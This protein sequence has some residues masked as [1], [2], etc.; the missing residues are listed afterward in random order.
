MEDVE[1]DCVLFLDEMEIATGV[2]LYR[3]EDT[4]LGGI[5]LPLKPKEPANKALVFMVGRLNQRWKQ[6]VAY[7]FTGRNVD[8]SLLKSYVLELVQLC[9]QISLRVRVVTSDM[10]PANQALWREFGFSSH[11]YSLTV[12]SIPHPCMRYGATRCELARHGKKAPR[13][14]FSTPTQLTS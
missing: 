1:K 13:S 12:C 4:L 3:A 8:G 10:G 6:V 7:E 11:R 14:F 9:S 5:T 2:E